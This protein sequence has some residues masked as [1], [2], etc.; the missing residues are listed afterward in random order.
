MEWPF[1]LREAMLLFHWSARGRKEGSLPGAALMLS[2][3][4]LSGQYGHTHWLKEVQN[5]G[6]EKL[7]GTEQ[8]CLEFPER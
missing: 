8:I 1:E 4:R 3:L 2:C 6:T 7:H 5:L